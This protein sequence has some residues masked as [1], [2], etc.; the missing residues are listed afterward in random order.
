LVSHEVIIN[1]IANTST[2]QGLRI[3]A[4]LDNA[5]Y[6][7]QTKITDEELASVKIKRHKFHG[8][9]NYSIRPA[10]QKSGKLF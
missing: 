10:K 7:L 3:Q 6:P 8:D 2:N 1:L 9:W 5:T 4:E